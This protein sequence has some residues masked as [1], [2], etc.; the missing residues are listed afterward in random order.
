MCSTGHRPYGCR[1]TLMTS[2]IWIKSAP[3]EQ[4]SS[5]LRSALP[6]YRSRADSQA[7]ST[8]PS[9][10]GK[11]RQ[12]PDSNRRTLPNSHDSGKLSGSLTAIHKG[13]RAGAA[14]AGGAIVIAKYQR[15]VRIQACPK[16]S[17][18][19]DVSGVTNLRRCRLSAEHPVVCWLPARNI[20]SQLTSDRRISDRL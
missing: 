19:R 8:K 1:G 5:L 3:Q 18:A 11:S 14:Q 6:A 20:T 12:I 15:V 4:S 9:C 7:H 16:T 10:F 13:Q 17:V 2:R